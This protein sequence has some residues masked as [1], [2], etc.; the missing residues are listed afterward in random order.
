MK[1]TLFAFFASL[2]LLAIPLSVKMAVK[3]QQATLTV[4]VGVICRNVV[5]RE[6]VEPGESFEATVGDLFCFTKIVGAKEPVKITHVWYYGETE[7][8]RIDL[9][10]SSASWRTW[11]SKTIQASDAGAWHVDILGPDQAVLKTLKFEIK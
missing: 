4:D 11:S 5:D 8:F 1:K 10:V 3:A 7:R 6:P 9:D 2:L